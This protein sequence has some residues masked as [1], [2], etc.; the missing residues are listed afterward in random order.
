M[1]EP[2]VRVRVGAESYALAVAHVL[3]VRELDDLRVVPGA[4]P[5]ILGVLNLRGLVLTVFD[6]GRVL[7]IPREGRPAR[8][9]VADLAGQAAGLA[10]DEVIDVAPLTGNVEQASAEHLAGATLEHGELVGLIDAGGLRT[11]LERSVGA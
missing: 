9:V 8:L 6:L 1:T 3:E 5:S 7:G 2:Q 10:V 4:A 11:V